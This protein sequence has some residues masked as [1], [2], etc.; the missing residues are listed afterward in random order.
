MTTRRPSFCWFLLSL[1]GLLAVFLPLSSPLAKPLV[2]DLSAHIIR[3]DSGFSGIDVM[4]FGARQE[5]GDI[6]VVIR[7]PEGR[8]VVRK[9]S[10]IAG[11]W[12]NTEKTVFSGVPQFYAMAA[13]HPRLF[14]DAPLLLE[15]LQ[16]G[17]ERLAITAEE[18][19]TAEEASS[20]GQAL[21]RHQAKSGRFPSEIV[22]IDFMGETLFR[23]VIRLPDHAPRG[24]YTA[25]VYLINDGA[26]Q[27][28]QVIPLDIEKTGLDAFLYQLAHEQSALY[29]IL[30][31][32]VAL[33]A[34]WLAGYIFNR[35]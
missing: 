20:F 15:A 10:R 30:A 13:S 16:I 24:R 12:I 31:V 7:G 1:G 2:A 28:M 19:A 3:I 33:S 35:L 23:T 6:A 8:M 9:K 34:G 17:Q 29:G 4:L 18:E 22:P 32:L 21:I 26:L 11:M 27:G 5:A 14:E 25:E